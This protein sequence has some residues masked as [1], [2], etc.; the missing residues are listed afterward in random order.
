[1]TTL[2]YAA[3]SIGMFSIVVLIISAFTKNKNN[4]WLAFSA[5]SVWFLLF[6]TLL[7]NTGEV[8]KYPFMLRTGNFFAYL[9]YPFLFIYAYNSFYPPARWKAWFFLLFIPAGIYFIDLLPFLLLPA[10]EKIAIMEPLLQNR[11]ERIKIDQGWIGIP[12]LHAVLRYLWSLVVLMLLVRLVYRNYYLLRSKERV[13]NRVLFRIIMAPT[14]AYFPLFFIAAV[15]ASAQLRMGGFEVT[16][17]I[18]S[19][20]L[21]GLAFCIQLFPGILYGLQP[22]KHSLSNTAPASI[23]VVKADRADQENEQNDEIAYQ[24][25]DNN[26]APTI[27]SSGREVDQATLEDA[28]FKVRNVLS[29]STAFTRLSYSIHDLAVD[30]E[31]PAYLVSMA[32][33]QHLGQNF[34]Q[35][36]NGYRVSQF[37]RIC[38][39]PENAQLTLEAL[40]QQCGFKSRSTFINAFKKVHGITPSEFM[41][42]KEAG[43]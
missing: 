43:D 16:L 28:L 4:I 24:T 35:F 20:S 3:L 22:F 14:I 33:N 9:I 15:D 17:T 31:V 37:E 10:K 19:I 32:I 29:N 21:I 38:K 5:F 36:I 7:A 11:A 30:S 8:L 42:S 23:T 40:A 25:K 1:M 6:I 34:S 2:Y 39:E 41:K 12:Y 13:T 18:M 27:K 26:S